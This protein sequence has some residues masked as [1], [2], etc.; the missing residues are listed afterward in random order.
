[1]PTNLVASVTDTSI[2]RVYFHDYAKLKRGVLNRTIPSAIVDSGAT[3]S[4]STPT[5]PFSAT[6]RTSNKIFRLPNGATEAASEIRELATKVRAPARDVH[7]TPGIAESSLISTSRFSDAGYATIFA[8]DQ[9]NIYDQND[10]IITVSRGAILRSWREDNGLYRIPLVPVVRNNN[11]DTV[12]VKRPPS[13]FLPARPPPKEA[14][15]NV[16]ELKTKPKLVRY[17]H[18]A[19]GFPTKPTWIKAVKNRHFASWPGLT[20]EAVAKHFPESEETTKGHARKTKSSLRSTKRP[21]TDN[22]ITKQ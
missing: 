11:T 17:L 2:Q 5:D 14:V 9:V 4:V 12:I 21:W 19:A 18:A 3:S 1:L 22:L 13:K 15:N 20:T 7:I 10:M 16:Y 6:G 8:G